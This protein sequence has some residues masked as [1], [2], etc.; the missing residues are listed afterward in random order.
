[1]ARIPLIKQKQDVP[2]EHHE[3][4]DQIV[5]SRGQIQGPFRVLL[6]SP[7]VAGRTAHLGTYLRF[8]SHL[9][10]KDAELAAIRVAREL[11]CQH[12]WAVHSNHARNFGM[13]EESIDAVRDRKAPEGLSAGEAQIFIYV[14]HL[15]RS[16]RVNEDSFQA[17]LN[18][19][20]VEGLVELTATVGYYSMLACTLN[21]FE[22]E[23]APG[24]VL[25]K[26]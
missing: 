3:I 8:E 6:R 9:D 22:V 17:M 25:H 23:P 21:A 13:P 1:M 10:P 12:E 20:G 11:D 5:G 19:F 16:H 15:L 18:R 7:Q 4:Y 26:T 14:Q 24:T 2:Q